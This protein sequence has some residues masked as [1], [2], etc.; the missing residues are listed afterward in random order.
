[1]LSYLR[2]P[3]LNEIPAEQ[4]ADNASRPEQEYLTVATNKNDVRRSTT[5]LCVLFIIGLIGLGVM[6]KKSA[7]KAA[8]AK[9][10]DTQEQQIEAAIAKLVGVKSEMFNRMDEIL[11]KFS[12][13]SDVFQVEV[14][15]LVK[16]PFQLETFLSS[17]KANQDNKGSKIDA[18]MIMQEQIRQKA[19]NMKL[20]STM[21]S[22]KGICCMINNKILYEGD[23]IEDFEVKK[24]TTDSVL[25]ELEDI[26][27]TLNL[28]K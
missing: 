28:S 24:I 4:Q 7:P 20:Y 17:L 16:N 26:E 27:I 12:E 14:N 8:V 19:K 9:T 13:F 2:D 21:Q 11:G 5:I 23:T 3:N 15:E 22:Q 25:L 10:E 1:M 6:I 18:A